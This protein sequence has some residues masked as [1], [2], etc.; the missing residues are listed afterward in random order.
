MANQ[1]TVSTTGIPT[2][3]NLLQ[4]LIARAA[5]IDK[6]NA[7]LRSMQSEFNG[8]QQNNQALQADNTSLAARAM[9]L[10]N[11]LAINF[12]NQGG[13]ARF[14]N[15]QVTGL[16]NDAYAASAAIYSIVSRIAQL[17]ASIPMKVYEV[18][19][20]AALKQY[21]AL[22]DMPRT[23][24]NTFK[25]FQLKQRAFA[26]VDEDNPLQRLIDYPN[27]Q[28]SKQVFYQTLIAYRLVT[29]NAFWSVP[30]L[31]F[32]PNAGLVSEMFIMPSQYTGIITTNG[33]PNPVLG[34]ELIVSGLMLYKGTEVI[35]T[36]YPNLVWSID[37]LQLYGMSPLFAGRKTVAS[38]NN[39][40]LA[41]DMMFVNGGPR[42]IIVRKDW[43]GTEESTQQAGQRKQANKNEFSGPTNVNKIREM[44][45][46][47]DYLQVG[48]SAVDLDIIASQG[49]TFDMLCN[50]FHISSIM[51]NN[52]SASTE[53]NVKEMRRDSWT[54]A[55]IPEIQAI[56]DGFNLRLTG[57]YGKKLKKKF[58]VDL[59]ISGIPELQPDMATMT[60]WLAAAYW[61][62]PNEKR[63]YQDFARDPNPDM[64]KYYF[65]SNV[66]ALDDMSIP[67]D[68]PMPGDET[69]NQ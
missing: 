57:P 27:S 53:S 28:D 16:I 1:L 2:Q 43:D 9:A 31:D 26:E 8:M 45:G 12:R 36:R 47:V 65:P 14:N 38:N 39:G 20:A 15:I 19:D 62:T 46:D 61:I 59:D 48:L 51:F 30:T 56:A 7:Q 21:K 25:T 41:A 18:K 58:Y 52:K 10:Q 55:I 5:G 42:G 32:G 17:A 4:R 37:G 69:Q 13:F 35:H 44:A 50:L 66:I 40:E 11:Q 6:I 63:E 29:G 54:A 24:E 67:V 33:W 64:D 23:P 68:A 22:K 3:P 49:F 34:Y 60:T